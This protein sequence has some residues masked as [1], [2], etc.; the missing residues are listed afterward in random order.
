MR[1]LALV[2]LLSLAACSD[3]LTTEPARDVV[4]LDQ[5]GT[6]TPAKFAIVSGKVTSDTLVNHFLQPV[7]TRDTTVVWG[8][9]PNQDVKLSIIRPSYLNTAESICITFADSLI[10]HSG[11]ATGWIIYR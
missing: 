1:S 2:L 7:R 11:T 3:S 9:A 4:P 8:D 5:C 10:Y 6:L